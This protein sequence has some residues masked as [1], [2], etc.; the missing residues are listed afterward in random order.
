MT[1]PEQLS[2]SIDI[3]KKLDTKIQMVLDIVSSL[4]RRL[5]KM[6]QKIG[7]PNLRSLD[8]PLLYSRALNETLESIKNFEKERK[9]GILA[10]ELSQLRNLRSSSIYDHLSKLEEARLIFWQRGSELDLKPANAKF[11]S[12]ME[13][14]ENLS[15]LSVIMDLSDDAAAVAQLLLQAG[16]KGLDKK[17]LLNK[18]KTLRKEKES[19]WHH[20]P[21]ERL[22]SMLESTVRTLLQRVLIK[23]EKSTDNEHYYA[24]DM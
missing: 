7:S 22:E 9:R 2:N 24:W 8:N 11:Y 20:I 1:N 14:E 15:N 19:P 12:V 21:L 6:E 13:R 10:K 23:V 17:A 5:D 18:V 3:L 4:E 16:K